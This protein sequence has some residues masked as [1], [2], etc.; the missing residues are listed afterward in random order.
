MQPVSVAEGTFPAGI[1]H[2]A[3]YQTSNFYVIAKATVGSQ[4][5]IYKFTNQKGSQEVFQPGTEYQLAPEVTQQLPELLSGD[6]GSIAI[7]GTFLIRRPETKQL[8]QLW[9]QDNAGTLQARQIDLAGGDRVRSAFSAQTK[10]ISTLN[11]R[12]VYL[13]DPVSQQFTVYR[14]N[15]LKT[16]DA[17][18]TQYGLKYFF[19][20][21]FDFGDIQVRDVYLEEGEKSLLYVLTAD[22]VYMVKFHEIL[23]GFIQAEAEGGTLQ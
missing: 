12:Y 16:N 6:L 4:P 8:L 2:I 10:V 19:S 22:D 18:T 14:S 20:V 1:S 7:D 23:D 21:K 5:T 3:T 9:R 15:P 11:S 13:F 17:Y